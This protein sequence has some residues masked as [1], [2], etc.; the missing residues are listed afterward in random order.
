MVDGRRKRKIDVANPLLGAIGKSDRTRSVPLFAH[1]SVST[2]E[3][4]PLD[5]PPPEEELLWHKMGGRKG[6]SAK[7]IKFSE[8]KK[9]QF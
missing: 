7:I 4:Q 5:R 3:R 1:T 6:G 9:L 8:N 2:L